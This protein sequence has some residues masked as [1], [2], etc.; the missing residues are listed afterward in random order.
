MLKFK[1]NE[2][3]DAL[4]KDGYNAVETFSIKNGVDMKAV[5]VIKPEGE[6][7]PL[8]YVNN[9]Q[10]LELKDAIEMCER[11]FNAKPI[12]VPDVWQNLNA[13][14]VKENVLPILCH[15]DRTSGLYHENAFADVEAIFCLRF[16]DYVAKF[17]QEMIDN[18][19]VDEPLLSYAIENLRGLTSVKTL[20]DVLQG[21]ASEVGEEMPDEAFEGMP[22]MLVISTEYEQYG[23]GAIL[24]EKDNLQ[25]GTVL[26]PSSIHEFLA[27]PQNDDTPDYDT[28]LGMV[29]STNGAI[30]SN[31]DILTDNVY[32]IHNGEICELKEVA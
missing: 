32:V 17:K 29:Q 19:G 7:A 26:I 15:T 31:L 21:M 2:L 22:E 23:A 24:L 1:L 3:I 13:D 9:L 20:R 10:G 25:E 30:V 18:L 27:L 5:T 6:V 11:I 28:L 16:G 4:K 8:V 12:D 14:Y